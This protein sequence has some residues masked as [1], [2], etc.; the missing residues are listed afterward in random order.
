MK[1]LPRFCSCASWGANSS[2][3]GTRP[4]SRLGE[5]GRGQRRWDNYKGH[6]KARLGGPHDV[7]TTVAQTL[8]GAL[9]LA[10]MG[11]GGEGTRQVRVVNN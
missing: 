8:P 3:S 1:Q 10:P 7:A 2:S 9:I 4:L 6:P 5:R 11:A